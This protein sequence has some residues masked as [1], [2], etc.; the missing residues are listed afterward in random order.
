MDRASLT[1]SVMAFH[2][3]DKGQGYRESTLTDCEIYA[4]DSVKKR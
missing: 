1:D 3:G 4:R 2:T